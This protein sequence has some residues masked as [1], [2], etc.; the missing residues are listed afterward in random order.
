M[1]F[2]NPLRS[3]PASAITG[4]I[5]G[6]QLAPHALDNTTITG[7]VVETAASGN[8]VVMEASTRNGQNVG[9]IDFYNDD[10][11]APGSIGAYGTADGTTPALMGTAPAGTATAP[12]W[13]LS[14]DPELPKSRFDVTAD[15]SYLGDTSVGV[16]AARNVVRGSITITPVANTPTSVT[17]SGLN[18]AGSTFRGFVTANSVVP[19]TQVTGV[20]CSSVTSTGMVITLTRTNTT[21]T[22]VY[23]EITGD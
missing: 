17:L 5:T 8:R 13:K 1:A 4:Q 20:A 15:N 19:G 2:R 14:Y 12:S 7:S 18:V 21:A 16:L 22:I 10:V 11:S 23:W 6:S 9:E 3:L